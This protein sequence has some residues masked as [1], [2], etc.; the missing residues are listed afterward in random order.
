METTRVRTAIVGTDFMGR[1]HLEA[2]RRLGLVDV[3]AVIGSSVDKAR[4]LA[5]AFG[6]D[7]A[8]GDYRAVLADPDIH[9]VH[10]CTPNSRHFAMA[11]AALEAGKHVLCEKP[12]AMTSAEAAALA[13]LAGATAMRNATWYN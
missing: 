9:A 3:G 7:R 12:L 1:V 5:G 6:V 10:I 13:R 4:T 11:S 2:V 8:E